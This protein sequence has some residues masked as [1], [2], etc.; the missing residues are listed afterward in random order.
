MKISKIRKII[1]YFTAAAGISVI[2]T[3]CSTASKTA[4]VSE[5]TKQETVQQDSDSWGKKEETERTESAVETSEAESIWSREE[6]EEEAK[7]LEKLFEPNLN[8]QEMDQE[9]AES[10][11]EPLKEH[12]DFLG[13]VTE[14]GYGYVLAFRKENGD[15]LEGLGLYGIDD[16]IE[17]SR[18]D[19]ETGEET[20]VYSFQKIT[21]VCQGED[22]NIL[23]LQP[24]DMEEPEE[25]KAAF[26]Y[27][28]CRGEAG[29]SHF[30]DVIERGVR[31]TPPD[32]GAY[33]AV[34]KFETGQAYEEFIPLDQEEEQKILESDERIDPKL[35]GEFGLQFYVSQETYEQTDMEEGPITQEALKIA[36]ERSRFRIVEPAEIH[37]IIK[38]RLLLPEEVAGRKTE[39]RIDIE[40]KEKDLLSELEA[41]LSSAQ[42]TAVG[43]C[44]YDGI[45]SLTRNDGEVFELYLATDGCDGF[46][47]GSYGAYT[48]G[49]EGMERIWKI[50]SKN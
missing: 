50:F 18:Q 36:E 3:A 37:D 26:V 4:A 49:E 23:Y 7:F 1:A 43:G 22:N 16:Y 17:A 46:I 30:D 9:L 42:P 20:I 19:P 35:Y 14:D 21:D 8:F 40:R 6:Q 11:G 24:S 47:I 41:I 32:A 33:L 28:Y 34:Y 27:R 15:P 48:P 44:P 25:L 2:M 12:Y 13:R 29:K 31:F 10:Y 39:E 38:A 5:N 45:L